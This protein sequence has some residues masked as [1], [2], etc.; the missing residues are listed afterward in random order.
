MCTYEYIKIYVKN[1]GRR[2]SNKKEKDF[3]ESS[4]F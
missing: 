2:T 1:L 4:F 3:R